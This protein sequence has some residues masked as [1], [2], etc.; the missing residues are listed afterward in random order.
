M[1]SCQKKKSRTNESELKNGEG[2]GWRIKGEGKG[3]R[4]I[5]YPVTYIE[6][7]KELEKTCGVD[8]GFIFACQAMH[9]RH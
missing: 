3:A 1:F 8:M 2:S 7:S 9:R 5:R 6:V 4:T